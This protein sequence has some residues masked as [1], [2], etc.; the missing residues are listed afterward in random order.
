MHFK[1]LKDIEEI[2]IMPKIKVRFIHSI[3]MTFAF[4]KIEAGAIFPEHS[5]PHEQVGTIL[6][7][8]FEFKVE[9]E[10]KIMKKGDVALVGPNVNHSGMALT[11]CDIID[12]FSPIREDYL[13][14]TNKNVKK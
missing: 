7:G 12:V 3:N 14:L 4:W 8:E 1:N 6:D 13:E 10:K 2:E 11:N 5:H 9:N